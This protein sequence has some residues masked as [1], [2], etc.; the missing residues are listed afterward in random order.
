MCYCA[1]Q[2]HTAGA[3]SLQPRSVYYRRTM[4]GIK[5]S[6]SP[7]TPLRP[8]RYLHSQKPWVR[9]VHVDFVP[10]T[11]GPCLLALDAQGAV[12]PALQS[13]LA[14]HLVATGGGAGLAPRHR[15]GA[16]RTLQ[17]LHLLGKGGGMQRPP[18]FREV[19]DGLVQQLA[20]Q[21]AG[22]PAMLLTCLH[23]AARLGVRGSDP[24]GELLLR[25]LAA[26]LAPVPSTA[27]LPALTSGG[28]EAA[29]AISSSAAP[30]LKAL[31][32]GRRA[33]QP[34]PA[35]PHST[36]GE[37][38]IRPWQE[39]VVPQQQPGWDALNGPRIS[40]QQRTDPAEAAL[41]PPNLRF[42][43]VRLQDVLPA[44][45]ALSAFRQQQQGSNQPF[46]VRGPQKPLS[47]AQCAHTAAGIV[48]MRC[49]GPAAEQVLSSVAQAAGRALTNSSDVAVVAR[50]T[51]AFGA[52]AGGKGKEPYASL[53]AKLESWAEAQVGAYGGQ[54]AVR[55][56][57]ALS[58]WGPGHSPLVLKKMADRALRGPEAVAIP[59]QK[60]VAALPLKKQVRLHAA[61]GAACLSVANTTEHKMLPMLLAA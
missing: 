2:S 52:V 40:Q 5:S 56:A 21:A 14:A 12:G 27:E 54:G 46:L 42:K 22:K 31:A 37:L 33:K 20:G 26:S 30:L 25:Q 59:V 8:S 47:L 38:Q 17:L 10:A 34:A 4:H 50:L 49:T 9:Q 29:Q 36:G 48:H 11:L 28:P 13:A 60:W 58:S 53:L 44:P 7:P 18:G 57:A 61:L 35:P 3:G 23:T 41:L 55:M 1:L 15:M 45:N 43:L 24:G 19:V 39:V 51:A 6:P 16:T 32:A